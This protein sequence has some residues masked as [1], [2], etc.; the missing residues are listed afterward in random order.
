MH[1]TQGDSYGTGTGI[2]TD[3]I[4]V[5]RDAVD[6]ST[7]ATQLRHQEMNAIQ[8]EICNVVEAEFGSGSLNAE[9]ESFTDMDQLNTAIEAKLK[10]TRIDNDST[11]TGSQ[12]SDALEQLEGKIGDLDSSDITDVSGITAGNVTDALTTLSSAISDLTSDDI[13]NASTVDSGTGSITD[14]LNSLQSTITDLSS[15]DIDNASTLNGGAGSL[16]DALNNLS[17]D[18]VSNNSDIP[19]PDSNITASDTTSIINVLSRFNGKILR[20]MELEV[21]GSATFKV[22]PGICYDSNGNTLLQLDSALEKDITAGTG[23]YWSEGANG[24]AMPYNGGA[25]S[26]AVGWWF[27]FAILL[28][29]GSVDIGLSPARVNPNG[30]NDVDEDATQLSNAVSQRGKS[31]VAYRRIGCIP[32][33]DNSGTI[34]L[35]QQYGYCGHNFFGFGAFNTNPWDD[36]KLLPSPGWTGGAWNS[37]TLYTVRSSVIT[38]SASSYDVAFPPVTENAII[39]RVNFTTPVNP[40]APVSA[41]IRGKIPAFGWGPVP[42]GFCNFQEIDTALAHTVDLS[43]NDTSEIDV[44]DWANVEDELM[45]RVVGFFDDR[46]IDITNGLSPW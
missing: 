43:V 27:V 31:V 13:D 29:D 18:E 24:G 41:S 44:Y 1:R 20:G 15:D 26:P 30:T 16:T 21:T 33:W 36:Y 6:A 10:A 9:T 38:E 11:V 28:N 17:S 23:Q 7:P 42:Y 5:Y 25:V 34:E 2:Y 46:G 32:M 37:K 8:E 45:Y 22:Y 40:A 14:A 12:V 3:P 19:G 35:E 39:A 4:S